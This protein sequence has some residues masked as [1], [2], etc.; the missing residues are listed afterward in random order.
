MV[1][2]LKHDLS[3]TFPPPVPLPKGVPVLIPTTSTTFTAPKNPSLLSI[4]LFNLFTLK[5][6]GSSGGSGKTMEPWLSGSTTFFVSTT[7]GGGKCLV[8]P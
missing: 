8:T 5:G 1:P 2:N 3:T 7:L 6:S 4:L